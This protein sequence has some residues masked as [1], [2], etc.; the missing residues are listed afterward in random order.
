MQSSPKTT[1]KAVFSKADGKGP[2]IKEVPLIMPQKNQ[3]LIKVDCAPINPSDIGTISGLYPV[4]PDTEA[5]PLNTERR[6]GLEGAGTIV[7]VGDDLKV[8]H[9]EGDH[10]SFFQLGSWGE[11][12]L[13]NSEDVITMKKGLSF[14]QSASILVNPGTVILLHLIIQ[15]DGHKALIHTAATSALGRMV[16]RYFKKHG[17]KVISIVRRD[18]AIQELKS[19]GS[20]YVLNQNDPDFESKLKEAARKLGATIAFDAIS[21]EMTG[22]ILRNMPPHSEIY[23]HGFLSQDIITG[24]TFADFLLQDKAIKGLWITRYFRTLNPEEKQD[25]LSDCRQHLDGTLRTTISK[26]FNLEDFK[27]AIEYYEKNASQGK[28]LLKMA[29]E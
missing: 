25:L 11:Y 18:N 8:P 22:K 1:Y 26:T 14:E 28:V 16:I 9:K 27:S 23:V 15:R 19:E 2:Y 20:E 3:V 12:V 21:G 7:A 10:V 29:S 17:I 4:Y 5:L 13:A 6:I 24:A